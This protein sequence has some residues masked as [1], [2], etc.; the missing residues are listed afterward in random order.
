MVGSGPDDSAFAASLPLG[1][2]FFSNVNDETS[3]SDVHKYLRPKVS[4]RHI[5]QISH[6]DALSK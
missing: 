2:L 5:C 3:V 6:P 1:E 4:V